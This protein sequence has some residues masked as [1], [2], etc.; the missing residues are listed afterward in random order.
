[1]IVVKAILVDSSGSTQIKRLPMSRLPGELTYDELCIILIRL[2]KSELGS[3][4]E[5]LKLK[6]VD[7]DGDLVWLENDIG[8]NWQDDISHALSQKSTLVVHIFSGSVV[9]SLKPTVKLLTQAVK[10]LQLSSTSKYTIKAALEDIKDKVDVILKSLAGDDLQP[11]QPMIADKKKNLSRADM[12]EFENSGKETDVTLQNPSYPVPSQTYLPPDQRSAGLQSPQTL[13]QNLPSQQ[14][15]YP[16]APQAPP[17][18]ALP[19]DP[20][21]QQNIPQNQYYQP[22]PQTPY[23][24][25][26]GQPLTKQQTQ[27]LS[28]PRPQTF[29]PPGGY[30]NYPQPTPFIPPK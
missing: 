16:N 5:N 3:N 20:R 17:A 7:E 4:I 30:G 19:F 21:Q 8:G 6:Y 26:P 12:A 11:G 1:M 23:A 24:T 14:Q 18:N 28:N 27:Q 9:D 2:F 29:T 13:P 15:Y 25:Y 22:G 10:D